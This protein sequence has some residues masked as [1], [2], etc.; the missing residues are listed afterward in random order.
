MKVVYLFNIRKYHAV[1][2]ISNTVIETA[3]FNIIIIHT[4][5]FKDPFSFITLK[6]I[7]TQKCFRNMNKI[8]N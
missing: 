3:Y 2:L 7:K 5:Y 4:Y 6:K 8:S 1:K